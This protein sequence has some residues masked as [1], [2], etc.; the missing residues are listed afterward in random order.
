M[1]DMNNSHLPCG[2]TTCMPCAINIMFAYFNLMS[3]YNSSSCIKCKMS[4][5][6]KHSEAKNASSSKTKK[7]THISKS[8]DSPVKDKHTEMSSI[9]VEIKAVNK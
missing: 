1:R 4:M 6:N 2:D 8:S 9:D 5:I 3:A 7:N